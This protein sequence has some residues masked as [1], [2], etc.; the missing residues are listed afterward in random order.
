[1]KEEHHTCKWTDY[2]SECEVQ[3]LEAVICALE[4]TLNVANT[5]YVSV[6]A[7]NERLERQDEVHMKT[8]RSLLT[9]IDAW[10]WKLC[11]TRKHLQAVVNG[12]FND[13]GAEPSVSVHGR[14]V[15]EART[16]LK[17]TRSDTVST[18]LAPK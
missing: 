14:A 9:Q 8:R 5:S 2:C 10:K 7:E 11:D 1:M 17:A 6:S 12:Y 13:S 15:D 18:E 16:Y 4:G 3:K